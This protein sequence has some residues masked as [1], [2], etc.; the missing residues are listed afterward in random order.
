MLLSTPVPRA[1]AK[2]NIFAV[3]LEVNRK[4]LPLQVVNEQYE[5]LIF[6]EPVEAFYHRVTNFTP[7]VA[8]PIPTIAP[9]YRVFEPADDLHKI[10][11]ARQKVAHMMASVKRQFE[12]LA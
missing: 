2:A 12:S 9:H 7:P 6:S 8:F 4:A 3:F 1:D 5:E 11:Q 10:D